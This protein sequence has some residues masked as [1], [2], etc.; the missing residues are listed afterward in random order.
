MGEVADRLVR[1]MMAFVEHIKGV[2]RI[3]QH[4][5]AAECQVGQHHVVVGDY[6]ID[7]AHALASLV[8]RAL[9]EVRTMAIGALAVVGC[10]LRPARVLKLFGPAVAV[11]IP[12]IAGELFHHGEE[13]LLALLVDVDPETFLLEQL[14]GG[15]LRLAFLQQHVELG[16]AQVAAAPLGQGE[17][18]TQAAVA[19]QVRQVLVH[20]LLLQGHSRGGDHQAFAGGLRR[21]NRRQAVGHGLAGTGAR[22][23]RHHC[24]LT[25]A[26]AFVVG[27]DGAQHL[28]DFSDH[29]ALPVTWL[30]RL[31]FEKTRIGALDLG[32]EFGAEHGIRARSN[33]INFQ[34]L[35]TAAIITR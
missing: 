21:G 26:P 19:H 8:E 2:A 5:A 4:S 31:G 33:W 6:H 9:L 22:L 23:D 7:L 27:L 32:F 16:Q 15:T 24:R 17:A 14:R 18:E 35:Q 11:A 20:D 25:L 34:C 30:Q 3:G 10:Q 13:Q 29:Q 12:F 28:G 1:Q